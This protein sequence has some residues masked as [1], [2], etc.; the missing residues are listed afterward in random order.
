[1]TKID[2]RSIVDEIQKTHHCRVDVSFHADKGGISAFYNGNRADY[3]G[4]VIWVLGGPRDGSL[5]YYQEQFDE[6]AAQVSPEETPYEVQ[7]G[8][9]CARTAQFATF[10]LALAFYRGYIAARDYLAEEPRKHSVRIV[11]TAKHDGGKHHGLTEDE[12]AAIE[13]VG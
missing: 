7:Y 9:H 8:Y 1:M 12:R 10:D 6:P 3:R 13:E 11:N 2:V 4:E 5:G